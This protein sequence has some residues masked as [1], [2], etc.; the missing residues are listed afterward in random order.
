MAI[1]ICNTGTREGEAKVLQFRQRMVK[2]GRGKKGSLIEG[3]EGEKWRWERRGDGERGKGGGERQGGMGKGR[4][5]KE[6]REVEERKYRGS[7][8]Q[9]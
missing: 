8:H 5:R 4:T 1:L 9:R 7:G 6:R 2:G 3:K